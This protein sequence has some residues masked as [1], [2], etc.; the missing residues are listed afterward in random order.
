MSTFILVISKD[1]AVDLCLNLQSRMDGGYY[2]WGKVG[3]S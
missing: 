1:R 2:F 3:S